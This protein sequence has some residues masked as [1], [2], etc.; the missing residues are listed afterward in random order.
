LVLYVTDNC[1][2]LS[3]VQLKPIPARVVKST[4]VDFDVFTL[5]AIEIAEHA[6]HV[7]REIAGVVDTER[8]RKWL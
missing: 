2:W 6:V 8:D 5:D 3:A 1:F 4:F 7:E